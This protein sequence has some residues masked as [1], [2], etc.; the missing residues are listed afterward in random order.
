MRCQENKLVWEQWLDFS[1]KRGR[2]EGH[3]W[4]R[5]TEERKKEVVDNGTLCESYK[6]L[7]REA[8]DLDLSERRLYGD[9]IVWCGMA[10]GK[11][12]PNDLR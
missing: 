9:R 8:G 12:V 4:L 6:D 11:S 10:F 3:G 7:V 2:R 5:M 1:Q